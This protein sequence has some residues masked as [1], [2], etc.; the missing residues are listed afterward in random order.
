MEIFP[1]IDLIC[2]N[3]VRLKEGKYD[4]AKTYYSSPEEAIELFIKSGAKNLHVVDLDGAIENSNNAK[5]IEK[6]AKTYDIFIEVGG[7]I[8]DKRAVERYL[9]VGVN[10]V[11]LGTAAVENLKMVETLTA[12]YGNAIAVGVDAKCGKVMTRGWTFDTGLDSLEF[13]KT[14]KNIGVETVIYTDISKDGMMQ[15]TNLGVYQV[16]CQKYYPKIIASGGISCLS[17]IKKLKE[18]GV[19]GAI[20]GKALYEGKL[21]LCEALKI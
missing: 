14:L 13:C 8:R 20:L 21:N 12:E 11:I 16:L 17:E 15:G 6:I 2:G 10:R 1:A 9:S 5:I 18:I 3:V 19:S 4:T 7:G